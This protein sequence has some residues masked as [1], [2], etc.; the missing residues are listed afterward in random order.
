MLALDLHRFDSDDRQ[1]IEI[2]Q[3]N[4]LRM[5]RLLDDVLLL[6][7]IDRGEL[8]L[9]PRPQSLLL[10]VKE[11]I[12]R[13]GPL[14]RDRKVQFELAEDLEGAQVQADEARLARVVAALIGNAA[15]FVNSGGVVRISSR[16]AEGRCSLVVSDDG[17]GLREEEAASVFQRF[18]RG[19]RNVEGHG[20]AGL[21]LAIA[22]ELALAMD[23]EL[24][25]ESSDETGCCFVLTLPAAD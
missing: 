14:A 4:S 8:G 7:R 21:G 9:E 19:T 6:G 16:E 3:R 23:G 2:I 13:F 10:Q 15:R 20:G 17:P 1:L 24:S 25:L 18:V 12:R 22:R 11:Q 5:I